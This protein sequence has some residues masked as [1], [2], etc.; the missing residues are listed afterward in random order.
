M[1]TGAVNAVLPSAQN[2]TMTA[3]ISLNYTYIIDIFFDNTLLC[4]TYFVNTRFNGCCIVSFTYKKPSC[5]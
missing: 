4:F 2:P 1:N 5:R 3:V